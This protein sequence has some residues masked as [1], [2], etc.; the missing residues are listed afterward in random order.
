M[1]EQIWGQ[2]KYSQSRDIV[3]YHYFW[4][5]FGKC[6]GQHILVSCKNTRY[7]SRVN[8]TIGTNIGALETTLEPT[9]TPKFK[10]QLWDK[11]S[12]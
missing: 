4:D 10:G 11:T 6:N 2:I 9:Q 7:M 8:S 12:L 5:I 1:F 3:G